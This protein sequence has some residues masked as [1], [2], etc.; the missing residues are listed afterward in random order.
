MCLPPVGKG[1]ATDNIERGAS[2]DN[3]L[4][5]AANG[6][7]RANGGGSDVGLM[8]QR[9]KTVVCLRVRISDVRRCAAGRGHRGGVRHLGGSVGGRKLRSFEDVRAKVDGNEKWCVR[10]QEFLANRPRID[11]RKLAG[12]V[13]PRTGAARAT[14]SAPSCA[15]ATAVGAKVEEKGYDGRGRRRGASRRTE[16][17]TVRIETSPAEGASSRRCGR[18]RGTSRLGFPYASSTGMGADAVESVSSPGAEV[19]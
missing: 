15:G 1:V 2:F 5:G 11:D 6:K 16:R 4:G 19:A 13:T 3:D 12:A 10:Y 9:A 14:G 7:R 17:L 8:G 18:G